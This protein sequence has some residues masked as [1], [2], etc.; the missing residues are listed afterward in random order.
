MPVEMLS[1]GI[2]NAIAMVADLAFRAYKLNPHLGAEAAR[3]TPG[4][5]LID[6][7]DMFLHPAWQQT[8]V[9]SL[10]SAFPSS[11]SVRVCPMDRKLVLSIFRR[12]AI[13][14]C[15]VMQSALVGIEN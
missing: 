12:G 1:D 14:A 2:R 6:E 13:G 8:I 4:I 3:Q 5:A 9:A 15:Q 11:S 10:R 7:V